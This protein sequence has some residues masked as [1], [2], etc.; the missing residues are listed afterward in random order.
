MSTTGSPSR[1]GPDFDR[2]V[3]AV[4]PGHGADDAV[5]AGK[6]AERAVGPEA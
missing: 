6:P 5:V 2:A 4:V 3:D 1:V